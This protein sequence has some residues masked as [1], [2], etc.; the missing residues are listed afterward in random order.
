MGEITVDSQMK[1]MYDKMS[2]LKAISEREQIIH[3][4]Q[5]TGY[6]DRNNAIEKIQELRVTDIEVSQATA[7]RLAISSTPFQFVS[8][9]GIVSELQM[10]VDILNA[11][12]FQEL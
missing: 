5:I 7:T 8:D 1:K 10:Q 6:L 3:N 12:L 2:M 11:K 4:Y 9:Q